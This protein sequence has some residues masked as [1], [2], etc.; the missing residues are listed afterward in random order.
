MFKNFIF[1]TLP[2]LLLFAVGIL[3]LTN[4]SDLPIGLQSRVAV[5]SREGLFQ[6]DHGV[7]TILGVIAV[8]V[9]S[10]KISRAMT[11]RRK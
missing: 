10:Y 9:A 7:Q 11:N 6:L 3:L 5:S 1:D 2:Y 4:T 8:V